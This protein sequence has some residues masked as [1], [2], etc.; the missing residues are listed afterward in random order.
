VL[1]E[2][3]ERKL[4]LGEAN[5]RPFACIASAGF[6]SDAN[7]IANEARLVKGNL[8][9]LY[10]ALRALAAWKPAQFTVRL[11]GVEHRFEG[12]TVAAANSRFYGGGM[13]LAPHAKL[14]DGML[15]VVFVGKN[16]KLRFLANLPKVFSG[17]HI[18]LDGIEAHSASVVEIVAERPFD[19]YA[20]GDVLTQLPVTVRVVPEA[21]RV[22]APR[23]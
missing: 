18:Q 19:V 22:I 13:R 5:G 4:D 14:D 17:K 10:A 7:R 8:V 12:Y 1:A 21:M 16:S 11:D 2:G 6:D 23:P 3:E 15:D 20:D 9:Y